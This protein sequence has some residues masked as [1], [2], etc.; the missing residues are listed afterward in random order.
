MKVQF[1][2]RGSFKSRLEG[3]RK[4]NKWVIPKPRANRFRLNRVQQSVCLWRT[5]QIREYEY[6]SEGDHK[7]LFL[8]HT[9]LQDVCDAFQ[10]IKNSIN[11][12]FIFIKHIFI[13]SKNAK[14]IALLI[15]SFLKKKLVEFLVLT[16]F[17]ECFQKNLKT[18]VTFVNKK[19]L[20][21]KKEK[22]PANS[23]TDKKT[24]TSFLKVI[25]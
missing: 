4:K 17:K 23:P 9:I 25:K 5:A 16:N 3:I 21:K 10:N 6:A 20:K 7:K 14:T 11:D 8:P 22:A 12:Y 24:E 2:F 1:D 18:I 13:L 19:K 15:E